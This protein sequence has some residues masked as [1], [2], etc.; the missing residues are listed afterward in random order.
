MFDGPELARHRRKGRALDVALSQ[1]HALG[2]GAGI[3]EERVSRGGRAVGRDAHDR[4][5][6]GRD[7]LRQAAQPRR[8]AA[9]AGGDPD[10]AVGGGDHAAAEM[11]RHAGGRAICSKISVTSVRLA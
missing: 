10:G 7:I 4:A 9:F 5:V 1:R 11:D 3:V 2:R 8:A 6:G